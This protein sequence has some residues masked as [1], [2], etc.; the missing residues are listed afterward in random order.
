MSK[1]LLKR[2]MKSCMKPW[3]ILFAV[4]CMYTVVIIY[5]YDDEMASMLNEYQELMP[6]VMAMMGMNGVASSLLEW[7]QIYLYGFIMML[8]PM[9]FLIIMNNRLVMEY[10]DSG[11][12]ASLLATPNSRGKIIGTQIFAACVLTILLIGAVTGV[13][14]ASCEILFPGELDIVKYVL[15]NV[16]TCLLNLVICGISF[17]A[18]CFSRESK[19]Y[20]MVGAGLPILFFLIQ[21]ISNMGEKLEFLKYATIYTLLP[22]QAIVDG[23][24]SYLAY[25]GVLLV[26]AILL[27]AVGAF[28]FTKRDMNV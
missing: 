10:I 27:F 6:D 5:M 13:G 22:T 9:I 26:M 4:I 28:H 23:D 25:D 7:A 15:L 1:T 12:M 18:A 8:F 14:I 19:Y 21:M 24:L 17:C 2:S 20:Y 16:S 11:S 3:L